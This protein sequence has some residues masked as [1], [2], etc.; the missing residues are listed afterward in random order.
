MRTIKNLS[1]Y[2][3]TAEEFGVIEAGATKDVP[4]DIAAAFVAS[5]TF[6]YADAEEE[7]PAKRP[8]SS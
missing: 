1:P 7:K 8:K 4:D 5:G 2:G 6:A 3:Q